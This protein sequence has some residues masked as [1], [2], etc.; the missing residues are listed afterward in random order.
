MCFESLSP[1]FGAQLAEKI[2]FGGDDTFL[3][4]VIG[5]FVVI[6]QTRLFTWGR[7]DLRA[8][9]GMKLA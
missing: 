6:V 7:F 8:P 1:R 3:A 4:P 9:E 2:R 5:P